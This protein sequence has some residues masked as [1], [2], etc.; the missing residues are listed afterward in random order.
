MQKV[1]I[2]IRGFAA[3]FLAGC[4][5]YAADP[6]SALAQTDAT[7]AVLSDRR[8]QII[9]AITETAQAIKDEG[10]FAARRATEQAHQENMRITGEAAAA[11]SVATERAWWPTAT[12]D[13][14]NLQLQATQTVEQMQRDRQSADVQATDNTAGSIAQQT[15]VA[16]LAEKAAADASAAKLK[17]ERQASTNQFWA[18]ALPALLGIASAAIVGS[19]A[20]IVW[21][22]RRTMHAK[23]DMLRATTVG[24]SGHA[25]PPGRQRS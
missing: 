6:Y 8:G 16:G 24:D 20:L 17:T 15:V 19:A 21:E 13:A 7:A 9:N 2:S 23:A 22:V 25:D 1:F 12:A 14:L 10:I 3:L 18:W 5:P 4:E 11:A